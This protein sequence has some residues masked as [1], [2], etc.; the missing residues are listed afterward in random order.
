MKIQLSSG[1]AHVG[2]KHDALVTES[3]DSYKVVIP[4]DDPM[5]RRLTTAW[6]KA[7]GTTFRSVSICRPP[8]QFC[9]RTGRRM[10]ARRLL[11]AMKKVGFPKGDRKAVFLSLCPEFRKE[12]SRG[13]E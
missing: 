3:G 9:K 7:G 1:E 11:A 10:A 6:L 4:H 8:D 13:A 2:C 12:A 5:H